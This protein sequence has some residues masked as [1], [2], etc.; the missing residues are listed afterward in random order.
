MANF[1]NS[2]LYISFL[3]EDIRPGY[4]NKI[5]SQ[6]KG[7]YELGYEC[8]LF[9]VKEDCLCLY[10]IGENETVIN[11]YPFI[12]TRNS[13]ERN[14]K[15]EFYLFKYFT[16][17]LREIINEFPINIIYIRRI[18]PITPRLLSLLK[19]I[20]K[21]SIKI[22]YE[23]PTYPWKK[24][25]LL[26]HKYLFFIVDSLLYKSLIKKVDR[27]ACYGKYYE[28]NSKYVELMNGIDVNNYTLH[29]LNNNNYI[30]LIGVAH[31]AALHGYDKIIRGLSIYYQSNP[32]VKVFFN[33]VGPVYPE[34]QL[35]KLTSDLKMDEYV[36]FYGY[37]T[38]DYLNELFDKSDI[39][40]DCLALNRRDDGVCG[41]LKSREYLARGIPFVF[42]GNLDF[43]LG[44]DSNDF[45]LRVTENTNYVNI[46][47]IVDFYHNMKST[48]QSIRKFAENNLSWKEQLS[49][50]IEK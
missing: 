47:K 17:C 48:P 16:D 10:K 7:F 38:G 34:L 40:I 22:I 29:N 13:N 42:A 41:S 6:C 44:K 36:R 33:I 25:L 35:E 12:K 37:S 9:I 4:K 11:K 30:S 8:Y 15:D 32:K 21:K 18:L 43:M 26:G 27:I 23:Y 2:I 39:G 24:E 45:I 31:V 1:K 14:I 28:N 3:N 46:N 19:Y 50:I 49:K 20:K 5:H